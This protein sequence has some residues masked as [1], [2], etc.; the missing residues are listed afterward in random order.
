MKEYR[1]DP[2]RLREVIDL[3]EGYGP[4]DDEFCVDPDGLDD[5]NDCNE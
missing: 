3:D 2:E 4:D 5:C 1:V